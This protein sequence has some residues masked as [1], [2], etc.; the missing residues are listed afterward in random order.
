MHELILAGGGSGN[1]DYLLPA[2]KKAVEQ[3]DY[4]IASTRFLSLFQVRHPIPLKQVSETLHQL[5][6]LLEQGSVAVVVSGDPLLYS[7]CATIQKNFPEIPMQILP[8]IGSLQI[9][10]AAF[11]ITMEQ[12]AILSMH[13]REWSAGRIAH[14]VSSHAAVFFFCDKKAGPRELAQAL[15][16]YGVSDVE[17]CVGANLTYPDQQLFSG[18]PKE[19]AVLENP[20]F[21]V[22]AVKNPYPKTLI[23]PALLPDSAFLR[24]ES[25]MTKEEVRAVVLSK[26]QPRPDSIVWDIGAGTGSISVECAR[27]CPFGAVYALEKKAAALEILAKNRVLFQL[28][29]LHIVPGNAAEQTGDLPLPDRIFIGGSGT[30]LPQLVEQILSLPR[31]IRLVM[32]AVTLETQNMAFPL[33]KHLPA[34]QAVQLSVSHSRQIGGYQVLESNHPV[35]IYACNTNT[36]L[37]SNP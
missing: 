16:S 22:A 4:V 25:P 32:T 7:L 2:A 27:F 18:S 15:L 31:S 33:L 19:I 8:G 14:T 35:M 1:P 11:G 23:P 29:N 17:I 28:Q 9:L 3:A 24:N 20:P 36:N 26:L 5:P 21:C 30:E 34:F 10:G 37:Q 6:T 13:G 12:A